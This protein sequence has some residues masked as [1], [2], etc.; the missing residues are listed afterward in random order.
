MRR[1]TFA[2]VFLH[3]IAMAGCSTPAPFVYPERLGLVSW[4][5]TDGC[6]AIFNA[7]IIVP[8]QVALIDQPPTSD[9]PRITK[10]SIVERLAEP[11]DQGVALAGG[12]DTAPTYYRVTTTGDA[13]ALGGILIAIANPATPPVVRDGRVEADLDLDKAPERFRACTSSESVHFLVWTGTQPRWHG[14][15]Y[16]GYDVEPSCTDADGAAMETLRAGKL[17]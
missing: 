1:T 11:C 5:Q 4:H 9:P 2:I 17:D 14:A 13:T 3:T 12:F 10:G 8:A 7:G 6:L 15:Y 16:L